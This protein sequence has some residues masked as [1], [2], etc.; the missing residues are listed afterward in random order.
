M[1]C[2]LFASA[3][4]TA[5]E[6]PAKPTDTKVEA[7]LVSED[8]VVAPGKPFWVAIRLK[9]A[10]GWH[11]NWVNPGDAGLA[12]TVDWQLPDGFE[13]TAIRW[14]Y[15]RRFEVPELA[16]FG[17]ANEVFLAAQVTPPPRF[18]DGAI[19]LKARVGWLACRDVCVPGEADV[20]LEIDVGGE[21]LP[22]PAWSG[23][24]AK[25]RG[26]IPVVAEGWRFGAQLTNDELVIS[27]SPPKNDDVHLDD[28]FFFPIA[29]GLIENASS[30][31]L[32]RNGS[33]YELVIERAAIGAP[34][35]SRI[36]G[37][38]VS[39]RGWGRIE[40]KAVEI[41]IPLDR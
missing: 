29:E 12:P 7:T 25:T 39:N 23:P 13:V 5:A 11:V 37:V 38:L 40:N 27:A 14:P 18:D 2:L 32:R 28:V 30:Q 36:E 34:E 8:G 10:D 16:I 35:P 24:F 4:A 41:N 21:P 3:P 15:P 6:V 20:A 22:T 19:E 17:Y 1:L 33:G 9:M 26:E 31:T